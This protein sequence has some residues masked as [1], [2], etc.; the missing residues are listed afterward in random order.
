[1]AEIRGINTPDE[2]ILL[3]PHD[4]VRLAYDGSGEVATYLFRDQLGSVRAT[5]MGGIQV[6][7]A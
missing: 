3:Y 5:V 4:M 1:M 2:V 7:R 6:S